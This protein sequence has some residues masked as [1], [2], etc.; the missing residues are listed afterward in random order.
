MYNSKSITI[1]NTQKVHKDLNGGLSLHDC[2]L[3]ISK[4]IILIISLIYLL[5]IDISF[6]LLWKA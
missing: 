5:K 6:K 3:I 2:E 1:K 4:F